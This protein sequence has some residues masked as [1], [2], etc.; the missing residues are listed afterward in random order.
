[1]DSPY[2]IHIRRF[3]VCPARDNENKPLL[4][5][6]GNQQFAR[7]RRPI[8]T[9]MLD[10]S[11]YDGCITVSASVC[12]E[13]DNFSY[14]EGR[15]KAYSNFCAK[16]HTANISASSLSDGSIDMV[17]GKLKLKTQQMRKLVKRGLLDVESLQHALEGAVE[18][19]MA[20]VE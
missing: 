5:D 4:D 6:D 3:D 15:R 16:R 17:L 8:G 7:C 13:D 11:E 18:R 14:E 1:M 12:S 20:E 2:I 19:I 10:K 9:I